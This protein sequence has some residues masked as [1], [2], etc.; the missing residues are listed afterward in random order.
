[1]C[2]DFPP[3]ETTKL[4]QAN[5]QIDASVLSLYGQATGRLTSAF[6][7]TDKGFQSSNAGAMNKLLLIWQ[8]IPDD[9][10]VYVIDADSELAALTR[11]CAGIYIN[12]N[13]DDNHV[14]ERVCEQLQDFTAC[15][16]DQVLTGPFAEV[17]VCGFVL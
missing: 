17:V 4:S 14:I 9:T 15:A 5:F 12:L 6:V 7:S 10:S 1:L 2:D 11:Q 3:Y 16:A 8:T 13:N